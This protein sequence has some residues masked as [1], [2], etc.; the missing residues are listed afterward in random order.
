MRSSPVRHFIVI[1]ASSVGLFSALIGVV[2]LI[3]GA[4]AYLGPDFTETPPFEQLL[5][6]VGFLGLPVGVLLMVK[7]RRSF[8]RGFEKYGLPDPPTRSFLMSAIGIGCL[9]AALSSF[10]IAALL[11]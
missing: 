7:A 1:V 8:M 11:F 3:A 4:Q 10:V 9:V 2:F 5:L 6:A